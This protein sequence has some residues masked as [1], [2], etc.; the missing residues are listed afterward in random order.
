MNPSVDQYTDHLTQ[1]TSLPSTGSDTIALAVV[2]LLILAAG[3]CLLLAVSTDRT[4]A[5]G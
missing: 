1:L 2:A 4:Q 3:V 5:K